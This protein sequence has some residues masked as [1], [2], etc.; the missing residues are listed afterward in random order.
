[1]TSIKVCVQYIGRI[2]FIAVTMNK[3]SKVW[4]IN[5]LTIIFPQTCEFL[6]MFGQ[7]HWNQLWNSLEFLAIR[8]ARSNHITRNAEMTV[9]TI[10]IHDVKSEADR[11][12]LLEVSINPVVRLRWSYSSIF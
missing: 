10:G 2:H 11:R 12:R 6:T 4:N 9:M 8:I 5:P 1:M 3:N 7:R